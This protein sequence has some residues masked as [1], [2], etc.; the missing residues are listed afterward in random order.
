MLPTTPKTV[1]SWKR[2]L[3]T[4]LPFGNALLAAAALALLARGARADIYDTPNGRGALAGKTIVVSP[5]HG[6]LPPD[7]TQGWHWQRGTT[8]AS[9]AD[10]DRVREDIHT[11]E[12]VIEY[13][14]RYLSNAGA[15]VFSCRERGFA[16]GEAIVDDADPGYTETGVWTASTSAPSYRGA[17]YRF[18]QVAPAETAVARFR[19]TLPASGDYP[20]YVWYTPSPNR[21]RD[22][23]Y[24]VRHA[25]GATEVRVDQSRY[26]ATWFYLGTFPFD[27]GAPAVVE[28]SNQ[29]SDPTKVV[30]ADAV[31]VG[32]GIGP[33]GEPRWKEAAKVFVP[34]AG[35]PDPGYNDVVI[36][37]IFADWLAGN[38]TAWRDDFRYL[39][40][41]TNAGSGSD[42][43][44]MT[45]SYSN[46]RTPS[47]SGY[48]TG[49]AQYPT[50]PSP[51]Q[52][53][54][55][56]FRDV[57]QSEVIRDLRAAYGSWTDQGL[58]LLNLGEL[59]EA[60]CM[61]STLCE[62]AFHDSPADV[63]Y[64]KNARFRHLVARA[65]YKGVVRSFDRTAPIVPLAP[66]AVCVENV[67]GGRLRVSWRAPLDP[68][69]PS[70]APVSFRVYASADGR[71][72]DSGTVASGP[73]V[74]L[75]PFAPG[76]AVYVRVAAVNAGGESLLSRV[77]GARVAA[78]GQARVLVVDGFN[79][80][81]THTYKNIE[82][83]Y[84]PAC[85]VPH[86]RALAS[87]TALA[88]DGADRDCVS[89]GR[90]ALGAYDMV[91]WFTGQNS[92]ADGA[93][94]PSAQAAIAGYLGAG[95]RLLIS[96]SEI[97]YALAGRG[98]AAD[99]AFYRDWLRA[100]YVADDA[101]TRDVGSV[102]G[103]SL[104]AV[105]LLT[106]EDGTHGAYEV[107]YPDVIAPGAA[108]RAA[109][110]YGNG[111]GAAAIEVDDGF[112]AVYLGFPLEG[113]AEEAA[114]AAIVAG[115][116]DFLLAGSGGST[117][118]GSTGGTTTSVTS[119]GGGGGGCA[120]APGTPW[121]GA[122]PLF[123]LML[124]LALGARR[125]RRSSG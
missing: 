50:S 82:A 24:R 41:H 49:P 116:A 101:G 15:V 54:S 115:A 85:F 83:R 35:F 123:G 18:A 39:A 102:P 51:L 98:S 74:D 73:S 91:D 34:Y 45:I 31:R 16:R 53:A 124:G 77:S 68:L 2:F 78:S 113:V 88:F 43:G 3:P 27:A 4:A 63:A 5:G 65:I 6:Y 7:G 13:L 60:L 40:L 47:W 1:L 32:G 104:A 64:I 108:A 23:L 20:V 12:I 119:G 100:S 8:P 42:R 46:G 118:S 96:G 81:F 67:G 33:S 106:L 36:R 79:R 90:V 21:S 28:L 120:A 58:I 87:A 57:V 70:A 72:W 93:L 26:R 11:N 94:T 29:G 14:Q 71:G 117:G 103:S 56:A 122:A 55:D 86:G 89:G 80:A 69:E 10:D 105:P 95:G 38:P 109:L 125:A 22:A 111:A 62:V 112:R 84:G 59:R 114:R 92:V 17:G 121:A 48:G 107:R 99:Q 9:F 44:T 66:E 97:G 19:A 110:A 52:D 75:G 37:P 76:T 25:G 61:P 30:I